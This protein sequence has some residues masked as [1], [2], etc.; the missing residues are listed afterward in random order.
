MRS[1]IKDGFDKAVAADAARTTA[2]REVQERARTERENFKADWEHTREHVIFPAFEQIRD[3]LMP[4]GWTCTVR[5]DQPD[6]AAVLEIHKGE[7][8]AAGSA[9]LLPRI[10]FTPEMHG[11]HVVIWA[12]TTQQSGGEGDVPLRKSPRTLFKPRFCNSFS[13][14]PE[15]AESVD[16]SCCVRTSPK[17]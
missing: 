16:A 5:T 17:S 3:I 14:Y 10:T 7:M 6:D 11:K 1:D 2:Q 9:N 4:K 12:V 8:R 15:G 13:G